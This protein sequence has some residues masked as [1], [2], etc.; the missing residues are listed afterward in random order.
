MF[1]FVKSPPSVQHNK[2]VIVRP[3]PVTTLNPLTKPR[4]PVTQGSAPGPR[5][6]TSD[7]CPRAIGAEV[8]VDC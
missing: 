8:R 6:S 5:P 3:S 1:Y 7:V 4:D 2:L